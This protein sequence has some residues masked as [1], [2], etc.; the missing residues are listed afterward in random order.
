MNHQM[1]ALNLNLTTVSGEL[2]VDTNNY[3]P[4]TTVT[5]TNESFPIG[6][7]SGTYSFVDIDYVVIS[8]DVYN[9]INAAANTAG[10]QGKPIPKQ[11]SKSISWLTSRFLAKCD[12]RP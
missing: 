3:L 5:E 10:D 7:Q 2:F 11:F 9:R 4:N 12:K 6:I 1:L 8:L